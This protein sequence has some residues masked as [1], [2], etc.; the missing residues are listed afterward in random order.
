MIP[1]HPDAAAWRTFAQDDIDRQLDAYCGKSGAWVESINYALYTFSYFI[2]TFRTLKH[3]CGIDYFADERMRRYAGW[4][5]RFLGPLDKRWDQYTYP[6]VGNAR[7]PTGGGE[8]L[9]AYAGE[10]AED[11]P[12]RAD[13]IAAY[14]RLEPGTVPGE[15]YPPCWRR[16][17]LFPSAS[18]RC[19][20]WRAK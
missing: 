20:R 14:Q 12:L 10:L 19:A 6:G 11:D 7:C 16:W 13:L 18:S 4:L 17:R 3:R 15:H 9:L 2:I 5:T 1:E 8:Y